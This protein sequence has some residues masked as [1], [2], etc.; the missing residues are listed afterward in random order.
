VAL[1]VHAD[2]PDA[3][4]HLAEALCQMGQ[5]SAAIEHRQQYLEYDRRGPWAANARKRLE[6][7]AA[8]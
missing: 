1:D 4:F 8:T 7:S 6:E 2:Y 3:H 5:Q